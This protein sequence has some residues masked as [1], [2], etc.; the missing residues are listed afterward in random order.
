[1]T[2]VFLLLASYFIGA[3]PFGVL[4]ARA[5]G[6]DIMK[7]GSG[8]IGA[9][10]VGRVLGKGPG[11]AV[12]GL[13]V[14]KSLAPTLVA[15]ALLPR[16]VGPLDPEMAW[17]LVGFA[18]IVGHCASPFLGFKG[19]KGISTALG[20]IVGTA[21]LVA[22]LCF[23]LFAVVL[24]TTR[25]MAIAS[26]VGVSSV[27]V[28]SLLLHVSP[29]LL[30]VFVLLALFV[31]YRH[32]TNFRR[33]RA[34]TEPRFSFKKAGAPADE[35]PSPSSQD[36][37]VADAEVED[38]KAN[39]LPQE[40][41]RLKGNSQ[42]PNPYEASHYPSQ[43]VPIAEIIVAQ[44]LEGGQRLTLGYE[45]E[46]LRIRIDGESNGQLPLEFAP[47]VLRRL[48]L[49]ADMNPLEHRQ[50]R[51]GRILGTF[52]ELPFQLEAEAFPVTEGVAFVLTRPTS[53]PTV[54]QPESEPPF[55]PQG[56][57]SSEDSLLENP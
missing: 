29:Q 8:N 42:L 21:P 3:I 34:G 2:F 39:R 37:F 46:V 48:A 7:A 1:M 6:V 10:N 16:G 52:D 5:K 30:P 13:D 57:P 55:V 40:R 44:F 19:G 33:L 32:R 43:A 28:F 22:V 36:D 11:L 25:Y 14:L 24:A 23:A 31:A 41:L 47:D 35:V 49:V 15:R 53:S 9:T 17:F 56:E 18:A 4:V 38:G 51:R 26:V 45:D 50:T 27:V 20:A 54:F 12:W